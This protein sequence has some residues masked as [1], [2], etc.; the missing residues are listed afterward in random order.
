[1]VRTHRWTDAAPYRRRH[2]AV[3]DPV[4]TS[5]MLSTTLIV[6]PGGTIWSM[7]SSTSVDKPTP[8]AARYVGAILETALDGLRPTSEVDTL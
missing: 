8:S 5:H 6:T 2:A 3:S 1:M 4:P 7:R